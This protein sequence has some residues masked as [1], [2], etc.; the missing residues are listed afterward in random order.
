MGSG[1]T[2][3]SMG[4]SSSRDWGPDPAG[5]IDGTAA[6]KLNEFLVDKHILAV[7]SGKVADTA[8]TPATG[9]VVRLHDVQNLDGA[10]A[11]STTVAQDASYSAF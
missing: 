6:R 10:A 1:T 8:G 4:C 3:G 11:A 5:A 9:Y 2:R 7:A